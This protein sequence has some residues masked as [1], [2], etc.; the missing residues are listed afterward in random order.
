M[1]TMNQVIINDIQNLIYSLAHSHNSNFSLPFLYNRYTPNIIIQEP[2]IKKKRIVLSKRSNYIPPSYNRCIARCW[3][4][5]HTIY[6]PIT[7]KWYYGSRCS[8][9]KSKVNYCIT[10]YKQHFKNKLIHG[11]Y[12]EYPPHPHYI[13]Y[14]YKIEKQ[15]KIRDSDIT[16]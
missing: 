15:F 12:N 14:K 1:I 7:K 16:T 13:K 11:N 4:N 3:D 2:N 8:R 9:Y 10:H 5:G 6:N